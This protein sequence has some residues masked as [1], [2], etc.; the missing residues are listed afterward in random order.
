MSTLSEMKSIQEAANP[1]KTYERNEDNNM[2]SKNVHHMAKSLQKVGLASDEDV[3]NAK[4]IVDR[5]M[6]EGSMYGD[7][8]DNRTALNKK[9]WPKFV[10][11]FGPDHKQ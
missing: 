10:A 9:L 1:W 8:M 4:T 5:H 11:T 7:N 2:H 6:K 3:K